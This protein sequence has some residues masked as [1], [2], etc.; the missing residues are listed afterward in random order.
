MLDGGLDHPMKIVRIIPFA[1]SSL[2]LG[3]HFLRSGNF[4]LVAVCLA[5]PFIM[6]LRSPGAVWIARGFL[7]VAAFVWIRTTVE[8]YDMRLE[9]G[10]PWLRMVIILGGVTIFTLASALPLSVKRV[11]R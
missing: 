10:E 4:V 5:M 1:L 2:V 6:L 3:A 8:L 9:L 11:D 7:V